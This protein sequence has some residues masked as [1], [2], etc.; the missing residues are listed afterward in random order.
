MF[1]YESTTREYY[2]LGVY[3]F[4][5]GRGS[6]FNLGYVNVSLLD[7]FTLENNLRQLYYVE[8]EKYENVRKGFIS[9]EV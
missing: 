7:D 1:A 8:R 9:A 2:Y 4:N 3:N 6:Y 5:L